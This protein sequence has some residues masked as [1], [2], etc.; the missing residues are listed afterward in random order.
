MKDFTT[1]VAPLNKIVKK[2]VV[3]K[4]G[5]EQTNGFGTLKDKLTKAPI[6]TMVYTPLSPSQAFLG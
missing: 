5:Q 4:W 6:L 3:F 2:D 1:T